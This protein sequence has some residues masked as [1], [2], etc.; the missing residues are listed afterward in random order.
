MFQTAQAEEESAVDLTVERA[1]PCR[2]WTTNMNGGGF[3]CSSYAFSIEIPDA[4]DVRFELQSLRD[5]VR[6]LEEQ[7]AKLSEPQN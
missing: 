1:S 2:Y 7:L 4:R 5:R 6:R 3:I